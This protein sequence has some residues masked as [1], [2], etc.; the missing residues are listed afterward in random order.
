[1]IWKVVSILIMNCIKGELT[2]W[3]DSGTHPTNDARLN[4]REMGICY[5]LYKNNGC[6]IAIQLT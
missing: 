4:L 6:T 1:M 2:L 5:N 3:S